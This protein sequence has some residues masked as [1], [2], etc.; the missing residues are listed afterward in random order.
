MDVS[1][2]SATLVLPAVIRAAWASATRADN[3]VRQIV[4]LVKPQFE[5]GRE[6]VGKGGIVR[7]E[8]TQRAAVARV[9]GALTELGC[10][11]LEC[12]ESP[13][14]AGK[15]IASSCSTRSFRLPLPADSVQSL[16]LYN[17][18]PTSR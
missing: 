13:I 18:G 12:I 4:V 11:G 2:I 7:D 6:A 16:I 14:W 15:A 17:R 1:F 10:T 3:D 8:S 9:E 5:V